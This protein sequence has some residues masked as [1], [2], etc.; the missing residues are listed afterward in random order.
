MIK[1]YLKRLIIVLAYYLIGVL[2]P[3]AVAMPAE[4]RPVVIVNSETVSKLLLSQ[5]ALSAIFGM[6]LRKWEDG[7]PIKVF[8]LPDDNLLHVEFSK[9]ILHVFPYQLRAAWDRLVFSGTGEEPVKVMSEQ[10]MRD[11]VG[12]TPG[13]IGYLRGSMIDDTVKAIAFE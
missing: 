4:N 7:S 2:F 6:R 10:Q 13:A 1:R 9:Y 11:L 3:C 12:S 5:N 8:V